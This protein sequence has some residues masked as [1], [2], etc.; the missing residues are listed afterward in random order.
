[1]QLKRRA[2]TQGGHG[3]CAKAKSLF[4]TIRLRVSKGFWPRL[5]ESRKLT[6]EDSANA[7]REERTASKDD[8][9]RT[10]GNH[11]LEVSSARR[12]RRA[13]ASSLHEHRLPGCSEGFSKKAKC[14]LQHSLVLGGFQ[15]ARRSL[16]I[17]ATA[18]WIQHEATSD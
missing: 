8:D 2:S 9:S 4:K 1:M 17:R 3:R 10:C 11:V 13:K 18:R 12:Q 16:L 15:R 6:A 7:A 14:F 5:V